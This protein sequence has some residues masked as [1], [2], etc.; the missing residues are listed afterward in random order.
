MK[1]RGVQWGSGKVRGGQRRSREVWRHQEVP[2][3]VKAV[4]GDR[5]RSRVVRGGQRRSGEVRVGH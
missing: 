3:G 5:R 1:V 2:E 4:K